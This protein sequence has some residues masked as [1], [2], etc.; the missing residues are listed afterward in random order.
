M[1]LYHKNN[2]FYFLPSSTNILS[3]IYHVSGCVPLLFKD[4][5]VVVLF[6]V[7]LL[8]LLL[9]LSCTCSLH[10]LDINPLSDIWFADILFHP[11]GCL[12]ILVIFFF[13]RENC[14]RLMQSH[15]LMFVC[16]SSYFLVFM[17]RKWK[18]DYQQDTYTP[19]FIATLFTVAEV[20]RT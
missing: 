15:L 1:L 9:L 14:F 3:L 5:H 2:R 18:Q 10:I 20:E 12:F 13:C 4:W 19:M 8:L 16:L 11:I 17:Q 7:G 6:S